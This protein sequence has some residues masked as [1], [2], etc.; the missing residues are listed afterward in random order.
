[1]MQY[2]FRLRLESICLGGVGKWTL[3]ATMILETVFFF[4]INAFKNQLI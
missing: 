1:M 4:L 2:S 3:K